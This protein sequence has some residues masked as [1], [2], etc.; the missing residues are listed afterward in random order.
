MAFIRKF[1]IRKFD[2]LTGQDAKL[3]DRLRADI[4]A[5]VVFPAVRAG[6]IDF[7]HAGGRLYSFDGIGFKR[8]P[9]YSKYDTGTVGL[10]FYEKA[11]QEN[12][13]KFI[14]GAGEARE[15]QLLDSLNNHT[16]S[17]RKTDTVVLDIEV[18]LNGSIYGT[19][20]CDMV[21]LN[22]KTN[23]IMFVEGKLFSNKDVHVAVGFRPK[24][25]EQV[26]RYTAA[27]AEQ[28]QG[29]VEQYGN[30]IK[31][32]NELYGT[33]YSLQVRLIEK[34]KLLVYDAPSKPRQNAIHT[35]KILNEIVGEENVAIFEKVTE[36]QEPTLNEIWE[37]LCK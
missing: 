37:A 12:K 22:T 21:L 34:A 1:D 2:N 11:K 20:K 19:K 35:I 10:D 28:G 26:A 31:V 4:F 18:R 17:S 13:N 36:G 32:I 9:N 23:Q 8:N 25:I 6:K 29:I 14:S 7:Y 30:H 3:Y 15:R 33:A 27:I 5:G 24:V 16:F